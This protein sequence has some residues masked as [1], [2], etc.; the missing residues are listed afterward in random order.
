ML[1]NFILFIVS[2]VYVKQ[3]TTFVCPWLTNGI[4]MEG[5]VDLLK[6]ID[7]LLVRTLLV[8]SHVRP[9]HGEC[10]FNGGQPVTIRRYSFP[11]S[12]GYGI[13]GINGCSCQVSTS[14]VI[15][16]PLTFVIVLTKMVF[17]K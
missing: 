5:I 3:T 2:L 13:H 1:I 15:D 4:I 9:N 16:N 11:F 14:I 12:V 17:D 10:T 7:T 8:L 6:S